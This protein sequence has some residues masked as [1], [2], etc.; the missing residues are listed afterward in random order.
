MIKKKHFKQLKIKNT[1][2]VTHLT[3]LIYLPT[4]MNRKN[5]VKLLNY[6]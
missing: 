2:S 6:G 3:I 5:V 4:Y 1:S